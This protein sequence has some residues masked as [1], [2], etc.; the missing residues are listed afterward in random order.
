[1]LVQIVVKNSLVALPEILLQKQ[2]VSGS[3]IV[4]LVA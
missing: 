4:V 3:P 1:M 2:V